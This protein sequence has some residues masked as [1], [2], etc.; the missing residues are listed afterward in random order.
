MVMAKLLVPVGALNH[1]NCGETF[2]P[3][4]F[5]FCG[6]FTLLLATLFGI[7]WPSLKVVDV[8]PKILSC[9]CAVLNPQESARTIPAPSNPVP[10][11]RF[12][13]AH[14]ASILV[15]AVTLSKR[16]SAR[17]ED[18]IERLLQFALLF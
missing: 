1:D 12:I 13:T 10:I 8:T 6:K 18:F 4:Q 7:I 5:A 14:L 15:P 11:D 3:R 2:S 9:A 16:A 17:P